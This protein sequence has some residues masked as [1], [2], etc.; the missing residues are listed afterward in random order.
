MIS[1]AGTTHGSAT[2]DD[3]RVPVLFLGRGIVPGKYSQAATPA[4]LTPTLAAISGLSMK[5]EG[6][7]LPCVT[8]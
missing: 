5:A 4:D 1:S 6:H 3:Q 7:P 8:K 2:L